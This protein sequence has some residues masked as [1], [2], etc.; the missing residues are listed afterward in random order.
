MQKQILLVKGQKEET[1]EGFKD[2]IF[3]LAHSIVQKENPHK[4]SLTITEEKPP[5]ISIIPFKKNKIAAISAF[6]KD[7]ENHITIKN[8][9]GIAGYYSVT[10]ALP[11][12]YQKNWV[13]GVITPGVCLL[14]LFQKK[15]KLD[16]ASF[17]HRWH[18]SHTPLSL[19]LHPLWH[20]NRNVVEEKIMD[21]SY[22]WDGIVE[23]HCRTRSELMNPFKFFGRNPLSIGWHMW[24]VYADT[25]SFL[26]YKTIEP[27][28]CR[29][30]WLKS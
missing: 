10:E 5:A 20:Y 2:R 26:D 12:S 23:E 7:V 1:Y 16:R 24:Q 19:K 15:K 30:Y 14:T 29:E 27:Y 17:L 28:L 13:D 8:N 22:G 6:F 11:V 18:T 3:D 9:E 25:R 21:N 4:L